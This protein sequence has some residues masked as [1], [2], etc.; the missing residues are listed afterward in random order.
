MDPTISTV[1]FSKGLHALYLRTLHFSCI[2][3]RRMNFSQTARYYHL[4][5]DLFIG[6]SLQKTRVGHLNGVALCERSCR[7]LIVGEGNGR[8]LCA[9][10]QA[11]PSLVVTVVDESATM[12]ERAQRRLQ[13]AGLSDA[14]VTFQIADL[15]KLELQ[16][17]HYDLIVTHFFFSNFP[18]ND[19]VQMIRKL[20]DAA[21]TN[22]QW[23]MGDFD[24]PEQAI[25][26]LRA[27][28]WLFLL[29]CFFGWAAA[30]PVRDLPQVETHLEDADFYSCAESFY[31]GRLLRSTL[32][33][34]AH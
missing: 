31:C 7:V 30:V 1:K 2:T 33:R 16:S 29:Y 17:R 11:Y 14:S 24:L 6:P 34:R 27:K 19:V 15:R 23:L 18:E 26:Q 25:L 28:L 21:S 10:L 12:L 32:L 8:F 22:A 9:L 5:E 3:R 13:A 4:L 20:A